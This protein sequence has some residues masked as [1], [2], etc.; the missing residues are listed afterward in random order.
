[1]CIEMDLPDTS[2]PAFED[3]RFLEERPPGTAPPGGEEIGI[4]V[5]GAADGA[6]DVPPR[7]HVL[8]RE[9]PAGNI[10]LTASGL[11]RDR[12]DRPAA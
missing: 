7:H 12:P 3:H 4:V 6:D 11:K 10:S 1:M 8:E 9:S 2:E 5:A